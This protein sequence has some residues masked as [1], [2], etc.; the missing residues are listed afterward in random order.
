MRDPPRQAL[1]LPTGRGRMIQPGW[2]GF[3]P[4]PGGSCGRTGQQVVPGLRLGRL[5]LFDDERVPGNGNG[6]GDAG[7]VGRGKDGDREPEADEHGHRPRVPSGQQGEG[8]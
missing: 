4:L 1:D 6:S 5:I 7:E 2:G 8:Q 3:P